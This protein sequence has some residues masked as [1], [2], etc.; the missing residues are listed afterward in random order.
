MGN[1]YSKKCVHVYASGEKIGTT[2]NEKVFVRGRV[3]E[4]HMI[5]W[6][7]KRKSVNASSQR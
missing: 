7:R 2:C 3:C 5:P 4:N 1:F 6:L